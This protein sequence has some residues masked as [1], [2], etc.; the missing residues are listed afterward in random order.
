MLIQ[1]LSGR[2]PEEARLFLADYMQAIEAKLAGEPL[3]VHEVISYHEYGTTIRLLRHWLDMAEG[4]GDPDPVGRMIARLASCYTPKRNAYHEAGH[5]VM[6]LLMGWPLRHVTLEPSGG[7]VASFDYGEGDEAMH[8]RIQQPG[9]LEK[10]ARVQ[11]A[12]GL[13]ESLV[14]A[15]WWEDG[16]GAYEDFAYVQ[17]MIGQQAGASRFADGPITLRD[18][19]AAGREGFEAAQARCLAQLQDPQVRAAVDAV[20]N[21]LLKRTTLTGVEVASLVAETGLEVPAPVTSE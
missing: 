9:G 2:S 21:A 20:A 14:A 17:L 19:F 6:T 4:C 18:V 11:L 12:G 1:R 15:D 8:T 5:G 16:I 3:D 7:G 13:A 10:Y